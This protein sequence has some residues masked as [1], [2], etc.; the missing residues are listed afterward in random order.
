MKKLRL[1]INNLKRNKANQF[2]PN[3]AVNLIELTLTLF[4]KLGA[5]IDV[6][7]DNTDLENIDYHPSKYLDNSIYIDPT[8]LKR[9]RGQ[10]VW[11]DKNFYV[12]QFF[13][14]RK[15]DTKKVKRC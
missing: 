12:F 4:K 5:E 6:E 10:I 2:I 7:I 14:E 9:V 11:N 3:L 8:S 1:P 13:K 15:S